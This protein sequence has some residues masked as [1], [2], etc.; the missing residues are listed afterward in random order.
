VRSMGG[1]YAFGDAEK[2]CGNYAEDMRKL[3]GLIF[4]G[5]ILWENRH[6][7]NNEK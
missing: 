3:C 2:K 5:K 4:E 1:A 6:E 7:G